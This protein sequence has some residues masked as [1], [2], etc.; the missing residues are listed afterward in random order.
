MIRPWG[1]LQ[2]KQEICSGAPFRVRTG[3]VAH[4]LAQIRSTHGEP[5]LHQIAALDKGVAD[6]WKVRTHD[7]GQ[8]KL[9]PADVDSIISPLLK[10][11]KKASAKITEKQA[12]AQLSRW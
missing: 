2:V 7:N 6:R 9:T 8:H 5:A 10:T 4:P 12:E 11:E 3:S 1:I